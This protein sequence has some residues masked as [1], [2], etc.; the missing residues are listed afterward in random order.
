VDCEV[1]TFRADVPRRAH[2]DN[3]RR[4]AFRDC[5]EHMSVVSANPVNLVHEDERRHA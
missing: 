3:V 4:E 1:G 5:R 2:G